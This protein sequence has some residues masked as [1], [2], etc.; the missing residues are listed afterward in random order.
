[1]KNSV[2]YPFFVFFSKSNSTLSRN[3]V[4]RKTV[5]YGLEHKEK[6]IKGGTPF[7]PGVKEVK[8]GGDSQ[9]EFV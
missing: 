3:T 4:N 6:K 1:M 2:F 5:W 7:P 8:R 9:E